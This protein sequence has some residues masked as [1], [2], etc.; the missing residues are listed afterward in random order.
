MNVCNS[1]V[2]EQGQDNPAVMQKCVESLYQFLVRR[3][4]KMLCFVNVVLVIL[5]TITIC[6]QENL[7]KHVPFGTLT[8]TL[9]RHRAQGCD[10]DI[11][12]L[13]CSPHTKVV[14]HSTATTNISSCLDI[15]RTCGVW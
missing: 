7:I 1:R 8:E 2:M 9:T 3:V 12:S 14:R 13:S 11:I 10:G 5:V 6:E 15:Y 4:R